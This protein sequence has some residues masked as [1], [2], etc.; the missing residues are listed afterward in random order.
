M[1]QLSYTVATEVALLKELIHGSFLV[2]VLLRVTDQLWREILGGSKTT[3]LPSTEKEATSRNQTGLRHGNRET[4]GRGG[5]AMTT[6]LRHQV[7]KAQAGGLVGPR[8]EATDVR[9]TNP[10]SPNHRSPRAP[11]QCPV[12]GWIEFGKIRT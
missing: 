10:E 6:S 1:A 3:P 11:R 12:Q 2:H 8:Q 9:G 7:P 4:L 5:V